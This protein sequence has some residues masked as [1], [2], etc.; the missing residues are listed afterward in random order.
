VAD[1]ESWGSTFQVTPDMAI[2]LYMA[3]DL[4]N[5]D[6]LKTICL[7]VVNRGLNVENVAALMQ[8]AEDRRAD[9][10]KDLC[11]SYIVRHFD[12]VTKTEGFAMLSRELIL[13]ILQSR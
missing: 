1:W 13:E 8:M 10:I 2:E 7:N 5:I 12:T 9:S 6:A 3:V 11:T 4:Y